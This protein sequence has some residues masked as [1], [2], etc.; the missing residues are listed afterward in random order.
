MIENVSSASVWNG[1]V[2]KGIVVVSPQK[3]Y[4][5]SHRPWYAMEDLP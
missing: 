1:G 5:I 4:T 2:S 3:L